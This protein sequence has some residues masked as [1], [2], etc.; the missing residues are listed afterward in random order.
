MLTRALHAITDAASSRRGKYVTMLVWLIVAIVLVVVAPKLSNIYNNNVT[1]SI[2][3]DANSQQ[4][5]QVLLK[6]FPNSRGT[7]AVLV[8]Y[9]KNGLNSG[10][11]TRTQQMSNWLISKAKPIDVGTVLSI[12]TVPQAASQFISKDGTTMTM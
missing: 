11:N 6:E 9:D 8:F 7:S 4:A 3:S 2:P 10:D 12:F 5:Q 1:Q